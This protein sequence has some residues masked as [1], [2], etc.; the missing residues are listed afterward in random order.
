MVQRGR[1]K[2]GNPRVGDF[3]KTLGVEALW[4]RTKRLAAGLAGG[5]GAVHD[6]CEQFL[7]F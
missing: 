5:R 3:S 7:N 4:K 1:V 6:P 2:S